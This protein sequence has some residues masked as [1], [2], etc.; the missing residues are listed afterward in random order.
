[1]PFFLKIGID[2]QALEK[3][4]FPCSI[5]KL[6]SSSMLLPAAKPN[7]ISPP[8]EVPAK[9]SMPF[10]QPSL[11]SRFEILAKVSSVRIPRCPD[12]GKMA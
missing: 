6:L 11:P 2:F 7:A 3:M 8:V 12:P 5:Y 9:R 1:M 10:N 4:S